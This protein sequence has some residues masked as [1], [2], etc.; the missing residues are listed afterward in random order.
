MKTALPMRRLMGAV[1]LG[2]GCT[3]CFTESRVYDVHV[4]NNTSGPVTLWLTK[5]GPPEE[6]GWERPE[7]LA[8]GKLQDDGPLGG[9]IVPARGVAST[10]PVKGQFYRDTG[11]ELRIYT[12]SNTFAEI[13]AIGRDSLLRMDYSL[14]PGRNDLT[15]TDGTDGRVR[16]STPSVAPASK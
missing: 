11:A 5:D 10:G 1:L 3:G 4:R 9:V 14:K 7:S 13:L 2:L 6:A 8:L 12:G 15:L 16:V